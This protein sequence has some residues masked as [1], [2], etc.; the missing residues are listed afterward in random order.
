M[1]EAPQ[2]YSAP[3]SS[4]DMA[5][6]ILLFVGTLM[7][8]INIALT[9]DVGLTTDAEALVRAAKK[10]VEQIEEVCVRSIREGAQ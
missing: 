9:K 3:V 6:E 7:A 10:Y 2:N 4:I 5:S 8:L 1:K